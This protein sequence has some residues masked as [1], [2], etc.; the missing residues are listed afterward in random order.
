MENIVETHWNSSPF[1]IVSGQL[2]VYSLTK[3]RF[4][5]N[6]CLVLAVWTLGVCVS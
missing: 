5:S 6:W 3:A 4:D 1:N 2:Q